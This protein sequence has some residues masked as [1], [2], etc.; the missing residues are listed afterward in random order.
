MTKKYQKNEIDTPAGEGFVVPERLSVAMAE[1]AGP[2][3]EG[4]LALAV[5]T[6]LQVMQV[7]MEGVV[8]GEHWPNRSRGYRYPAIAV[9]A[10]VGDNMCV[11]HDGN[12]GPLQPPSR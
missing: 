5:G 3:R 10:A 11:T 7:L 1:V 2:L 4:L 8:H 9:D 6:G 12:Y